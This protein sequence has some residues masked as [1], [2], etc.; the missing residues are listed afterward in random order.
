MKKH[1]LIVLTVIA[2]LA[3]LFTACPYSSEVSLGIASEKVDPVV[4]GRWTKVDE[5]SDFPKYY[6]FS[7]ID[8]K[9]FKV[10]QFEYNS[11]DSIYTSSGTYT[12]HYTTIDNTQF[13]NMLQDG[14]YY[15]YKMDLSTPGELVLH[16]VTDNIDE[17]FDNSTELYNFFKVN[18]DLS[19]FYNKD[20][21]TYKFSKE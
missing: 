3:L 4:Y 10:E 15:F 1:S 7:K 5:Y 20:E 16:E 18:K 21:E 6:T 2:S 13:V 14:T 11:T 8:G 17:V 9:K 12:A 19:F